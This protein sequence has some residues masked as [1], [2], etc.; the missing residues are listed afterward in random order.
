MTIVG[1][2]AYHGSGSYS[3]LQCVSGEEHRRTNGMDSD[4]CVTASPTSGSRMCIASCRRWLSCKWLHARAHVCRSYDAV[5]GVY[6][7]VDKTW[8][9]DLADVET[10]MNWTFDDV[11]QC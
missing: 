10:D 8:R 5:T 3:Y 7:R 6:T 1:S 2:R 9:R 4:S 11:L